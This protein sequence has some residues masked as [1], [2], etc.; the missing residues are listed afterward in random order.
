MRFRRRVRS[1][2]PQVIHAHFGTV[3]A[4]FA[5]WAAAD[6]RPLVITFRGSD[7]NF[8]AQ[9]G[10]AR[11]GGGAGVVANRGVAR[12]ADRVRQPPIAG[13]AVVAARGSVIIAE[14]RGSGSVPS[15]AAIARRAGG[16]VGATRSAWCCS[17]RGTIRLLKRLDLARAGARARAGFIGWCAHGGAGWRD[18]LRRGC[19]NCSTPRIACC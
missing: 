18:R 2:D 11:C 6:A 5:A 17:T 13:T 9:V 4:L 7:L 3:T 8:A 12:G 1:F 19:R 14:R 15:G 10:L 16:W